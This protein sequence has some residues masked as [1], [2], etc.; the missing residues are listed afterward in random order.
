MFVKKHEFQ[1]IAAIGVHLR[2]LFGDSRISQRSAA[3]WSQK[4]LG[5]R[6]DVHPLAR[7]RV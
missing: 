4:R 1:K 6:R 2:V 3:K 7:L 5:T